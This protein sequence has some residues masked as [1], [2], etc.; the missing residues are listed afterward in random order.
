LALVLTVSCT[1][2]GETTGGR[3]PGTI[4][5]TLRIAVGGALNSLNPI[6][7]TN[8]AENLVTRLSSDLLVSVDATGRHEIPMLAA[9]VPTLENGGISKDGLTVTYHLRRNVRWQDGAPFT[10]RDVKFTYQ[11]LMNPANDVSS[12]TGFLVIARVDTPDPHTVV[13]HLKSRYAP[14]VN[15]VFAESDNP[16]TIIPAHLLARYHDLNAVPY[17][18]QPVGTGP[19]KVV[20]WVRGD[21]IEFAANDDYFLG[22][23]KLRR[24]IVKFV[25]DENTELSLLRSH[26]AD[27]LLE[28]S[29]S[30][31]RELRTIPGVR[32]VLVSTN[33]WEGFWINTTHP[34]LDDVRVRRA[35]LYAIDR[36]RLLEE[37]TA[38]T[39]TLATED[40]PPFMWAYD[41][42]VPVHRFDLAGAK[43][44]LD[45]AGWHP[46]PDGI[47]LKGGR[48]LSLQIAFNTSNV[49]RRVVAVALQAALRA[50]GIEVSIKSYPT[51]LYYASYGMG[52][53]LQAGHYDLALGAWVAGI[54]PNDADQFTCA[55]L[56]PNGSNLSRFCSAEL[57]AAEQAA[58]ASYSRDAR[59]RAYARIQRLLAQSVPQ[60]FFWYPREI[61]PV[62]PDFKGFAPN[63]V[64]EGWNAYQWEI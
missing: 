22:K 20:K 9:T 26:E 37:F 13:F 43:R 49:T 59:T 1:R 30:K 6:L 60:I 25:P 34:P 55:A 50:A 56:P 36:Q 51:A 35:L 3:H 23:P 48:R 52:G 2:V 12:R 17:N 10:S 46:G 27:W 38:G 4:P 42:G 8:T 61:E 54:D 63:P 44:L 14:F 11:A 24:I 32:T 19:F 16:Y 7:A 18:A 57:D 5:D 40:L 21:R 29:P 39:A 64:N 58:L 41:P 62:N 31:L 45:E 53:V 47:R 15:T 33:E 28:L